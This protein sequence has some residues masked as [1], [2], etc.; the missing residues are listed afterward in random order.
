M[1]AV[2]CITVM[3]GMLAAVMD[4]LSCYLRVF[5]AVRFQVEQTGRSVTYKSCNVE[6]SRVVLPYPGH[7]GAVQVIISKGNFN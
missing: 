6:T 5:V 4:V 3:T 1:L 7:V 2:L